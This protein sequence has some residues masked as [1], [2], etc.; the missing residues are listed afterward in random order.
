MISEKMKAV[1]PCSR[2]TFGCCLALIQC[3]SMVWLSERTIAEDPASFRL[4]EGEGHLAVYF[5]SEAFAD[6]QFGAVPRPILWPIH[7]PGGVR[8]TRDWPLAENDDERK[9]DH[10]HHRS[11]W[12]SHGEV[13]GVDF[14]SE[15]PGRGTIQ[16]QRHTLIRVDQNQ[17][18]FQS[19]NHWLDASGSLVLVEHRRLRFHGTPELR[20]I[21]CDFVFQAPGHDVHFGDTKEGSFGLRV[22]EWMA[23]ETKKGGKIVNS[24]GQRDDQAWGQPSDWVDYSAPRG[25]EV[26]GIC[27]MIHPSSF[28]SPGR[29][30]V[31]GYGLFAHNPFGVRDFVGQQDSQ[32]MGGFTLPANE[33]IHLGYRVVLHLGDEQEARLSELFHDYA[34]QANEFEVDIIDK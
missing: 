3:C 29:W 19:V 31:R 16:H 1:Y 11:L 26:V 21:D 20:T 28:A 13:N 12:F 24:A 22:A 10:P 27:C 30:H 34:A 9:R 17:A 33:K 6:Y 15:G 32:A 4:V 25:D 18:S 14:W 2:R 5:G 23:V 7:G 8:V